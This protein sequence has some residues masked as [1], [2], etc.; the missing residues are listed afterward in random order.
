MAN[1]RTIKAMEHNLSQMLID[2]AL[3]KNKSNAK[4]NLAGFLLLREE[5][6]KAIDDGWSVKYIWEVLYKEEKITYSYQTFLNFIKRYKSAHINKSKQKVIN[7]K[8]N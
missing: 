3:S 1:P 6:F 5:I 2:K 8:P 7:S 4:F